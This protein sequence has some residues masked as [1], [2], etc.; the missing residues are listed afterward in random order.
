[1]SGGDPCDDRI[2]RRTLSAAHFPGYRIVAAGA[3]V[4]A[5]YRLAHAFQDRRAFLVFA[6]EDAQDDLSGP[7]RV[8]EQPLVRDDE[9]AQMAMRVLQVDVELRALRKPSHV[10]LWGHDQ[11]SGR[12]LLL[13]NFKAAHGAGRAL[14]FA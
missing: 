5:K 1:M 2:A 9:A 14:L 7:C 6:L 12:D 4:L 13:A 8:E 11:A 3:P 10:E